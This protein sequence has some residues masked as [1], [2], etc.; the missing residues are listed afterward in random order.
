MSFDAAGDRRGWVARDPEHARDVVP[1]LRAQFPFYELNYRRWLPSDRQA[2]ILDY[3]CGA[4][5]MLLFLIEQ[6]YANVTGFDV[7]S[8][9]AE[10][11]RQVSGAYVA[12]GDFAS[13][14]SEGAGTFDFILCREVAYYFP[15]TEV[16]DAIARLGQA[17]APGGRLLLEVF[18]PAGATGAW[19]YYN[20][21]WIQTPMSEHAIAFALDY[22]GL[23][24]EWMGCERFQV[25]GVRGAAW[26]AARAAWVWGRR[27][28][29]L[30]ERGRDPLNPHLFGK[31]LIAVAKKPRD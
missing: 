19:P 10:L 29:F 4:G 18:N 28:A 22:A 14:L 13:F 3:G 16:F 30:L 25:R 5:G 7:D 23:T 6:D 2:R 12:E 24:S 11:S 17:L 27:A 31:K 26:R 8:R 1:A 21:P 20:D 15:R 9:Y